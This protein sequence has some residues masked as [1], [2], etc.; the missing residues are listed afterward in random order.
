MAYSADIDAL[1][2]DHRW[3]FDS[4]LNDQ[5]GLI[6]GTNSGTAIVSGICEDVTNGYA[7]NG[8]TDRIT[9]A[10]SSDVEGSLSQKGFG[11][12]FM[13]TSIQKPLCRIYGE[14]NATNSFSMVMGFGN[15]VTFEIDNST[16][17]FQIYADTPL[18][19]NRPYHL[20]MGFSGSGN[21]NEFRAYLDGVKQ[22]D[23][24]DVIPG[25]AS[26]SARTVGEFGD[27]AGT[28]SFGGTAILLVASI[29]GAFNQWASWSGANAELTDNEIRQE[30]FEK[31]A[32]PD[33]TITNQA[34]LDALAGTVRGNHPLCIKVDVPVSVTLAANNVTFNPLA[35]THIQYTGSGTL[36]WVNTNGSD[37]SI[38]SSIGGGTVVIENEVPITVSVRDVSDSSNIENARVLMKD[39]SQNTIISGLTDVNG[40]ITGTYNHYTD[41]TYTIIV[42]KSSSGTLYKQGSGSGAITSN[43]IN[44]SIL[45]I[46]DQ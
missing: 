41:D 21:N 1:S 44:S 4:T 31:G 40:K 39:S 3:S 37:A 2:P 22:L 35:S 11:G 33:V 12:W 8:T 30:L 24:Q 17:L 15:N 5:V 29:N 13:A 23:S 42:R 25:F 14:G 20:W 6:N 19:V 43:P 36:T 7:S 10:T 34:G 45:M 18:E 9:L 46:K 26:L 27:P 38:A 28:V 32:T 16:N